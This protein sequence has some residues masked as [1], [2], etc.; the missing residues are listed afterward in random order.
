MKKSEV[1]SLA[2]GHFDIYFGNHYEEVVRR[3]LDFLKK[4]LTGAL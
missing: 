3:Q 2:I 4:H 1:V